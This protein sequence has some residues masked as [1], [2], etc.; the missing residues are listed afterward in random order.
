M[1]VRVEGLCLQHLRIPRL[2]GEHIS[3]VSPSIGY[4]V[5]NVVARNL[6]PGITPAGSPT[7]LLVVLKVLLDLPVLLD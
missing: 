2:E 3:H 5:V 6:S 1:T 7:Q 4:P